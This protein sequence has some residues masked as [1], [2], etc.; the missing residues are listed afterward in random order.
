MTAAL[1]DLLGQAR[2]AGLTLGRDG[3]QLT[4]R[5]PATAAPLARAL[6][7][8][9]AEVFETLDVSTGNAPVLDWQAAE[10]TH[11]A[12]CVAC[13]RPARLRDPYDHR[14]WHKTCAEARLAPK[15]PAGRK[16]G[17]VH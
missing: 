8:R 6:L 14:P 16:G 13:G 10:H 15:R 2:R 4:I 3:D 9:K 17:V 5:A 1:L 11:L 7:A 12:P